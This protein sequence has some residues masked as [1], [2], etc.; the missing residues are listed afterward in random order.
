MMECL[1]LSGIRSG[2]GEL[3]PSWQHCL[4]IWHGDMLLLSVKGNVE[5]VTGSG[6]PASE[7]IE[8]YEGGSGSVCAC[9]GC[10]DVRYV[11]EIRVFNH[12]CRDTFTETVDLFSDIKQERG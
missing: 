3:E 5:S 8:I 9:V 10:V 2:V 12:S 4:G 1:F 11:K 7:R 6:F